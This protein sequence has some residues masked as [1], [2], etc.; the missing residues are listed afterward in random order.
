MA[1][2]DKHRDG[3]LR[4]P[5]ASADAQPGDP[6]SVDAFARGAAPAEDGPIAAAESLAPTTAPDD[7]GELQEQRDK[8]LRLAAEYDNYRKRSVRQ[9]QAA[10]DRAKALFA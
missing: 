7:G 8:Y 3:T 1:H 6:D 4:P 2:R 10:A 5:P 9:E